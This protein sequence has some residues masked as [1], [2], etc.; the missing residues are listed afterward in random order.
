VRLYYL[1][2][3][4][5]LAVPQFLA[6][7]TTVID[8]ESLADGNVVTNQFPGL[9]FTNTVALTAGISL[10]E[11]DFPPHSGVNV[12]S[13]IGG[14]ISIAFSTPVLGF[15]AYF[16]YLEPLSLLAFDASNTQIASAFSLFSSNTA[17]LGA[18]GSSPNEL[19]QVSSLSGISSVSITGDPAG[20]SFVMD[21]VTLTTAPPAVPEPGGLS[22]TLA[23]VGLAAL[24]F[25]RHLAS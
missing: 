25:R 12:V 8:F 7:G 22:L 17:T 1:S 16:T 13:D 4:L 11:I 14:P 24:F 5:L 18:P 9:T 19:L 2:L 3:V 20:G 6:A 21:D 23:G 10:N 15:A